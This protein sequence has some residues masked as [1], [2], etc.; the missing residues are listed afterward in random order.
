MGRVYVKLFGR[1]IKLYTSKSGSSPMMYRV[2]NAQTPLN[3]DGAKKKY[4]ILKNYNS[5]GYRH[6]VFV[7]SIDYSV[8]LD[9]YIRRG[10][11]GR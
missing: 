1:E 11:S 8:F 9:Q 10:L 5:L 3:A 4:P 2:I 6:S 7:Q